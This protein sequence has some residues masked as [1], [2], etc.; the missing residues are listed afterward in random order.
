MYV[1]WIMQAIADYF[2]VCIQFLHFASFVITSYYLR[3]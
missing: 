2:D 3:S 1:Y